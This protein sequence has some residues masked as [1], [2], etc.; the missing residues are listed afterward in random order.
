[1][2]PR[3]ILRALLTVWPIALALIAC[4]PLP[5]D[6][7]PG[8]LVAR[9]QPAPSATLESAPSTATPTVLASPSPSS[10]ITDEHLQTQ[11]TPSPTPDAA[12]WAQVMA[13]AQTEGYGVL[14]ADTS[15]AATA[16]QTF[17]TQQAGLSVNT[18]TLSNVD[19][20]DRLLAG[21]GKG[22][23]GADV[24]LAGDSLRALALVEAGPLVNYTPADIVGVLPE[25]MRAPLLTHH[26]SAVLLIYNTTRAAAPP[27][28]NW[29]D[30]T[31]TEW[32][33]KVTL[34][35]PLVDERA[36]DLMVVIAQHGD[37][38][39]ASYRAEFGQEITL[40]D[41]CPNAGYQW[42]K[43]LLA[44]EPRLTMSD[45]E[46]AQ[47]VGDPKTETLWVGICGYEQYPKVTWGEL[48]FAPMS[49]VSPMAG[50]QWPTYLAVAS[51]AQHPAMS[52]LIVRWLMSESGYTPWAEAGFYPARSDLP[53]PP[54]AIPRVELEPRLW[55]LDTENLAEDKL[56]V[57]DHIAAYLGRQVGGR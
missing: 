17:M 11:H 34:P 48:T 3:T 31:R 56:I 14:Y 21:Q 44:N 53:D 37:E 52:R 8:A 45:A 27:I 55:K 7:I 47:L 35:D 5:D 54:G 15:R 19:I 33:G 38:F 43:S 1:M 23:A 12:T 20:Q 40:N 36:L 10:T 16:M 18:L 29:W 39:A 9:S 50:L 4:Q 57:R 24:Y 30:L 51:Q 49:A 41:D 2:Q 26:W 6:A 42:I 25:A 28:D 13:Q 32:R 22:A 46:V